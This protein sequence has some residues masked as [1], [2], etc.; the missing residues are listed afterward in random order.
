MHNSAS[1]GVAA[2]GVSRGTSPIA[3]R[4]STSGRAQE[5]SAQETVQE[6]DLGGRL[7]SDTENERGP[8]NLLPAS[9]VLGGSLIERV[10]EFKQQNDTIS[11]RALTG[12]AAAPTALHGGSNGPYGFVDSPRCVMPKREPAR[13]LPEPYL[14]AV[15]DHAPASEPNKAINTT[16]T[17]RTSVR[18]RETEAQAQTV[19]ET[20]A[21]ASA[22]AHIGTQAEAL[23]EAT[24]EAPAEAL[25]GAQANDRAES[26]TEAQT[27]TILNATQTEANVAD[28]SPSEVLVSEVSEHLPEMDSQQADLLND[29]ELS[30]RDGSFEDVLQW[31]ARCIEQPGLHEEKSAP[32]RG[33][34]FEQAEASASPESTWTLGILGRS[35]PADERA[36]L[37]VKR[38]VLLLILEPMLIG[39]DS[40]TADIM[41]K[42]LDKT[43]FFRHRSVMMN[44]H[45]QMRG[46]LE[47]LM[48]T[49]NSATKRTI[50]RLCERLW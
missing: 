11:S 49:T 34:C 1:F 19:A 27:E 48:A 12:Q 37:L 39:T 33:R 17:S 21:E 35:G 44:S 25:A 30:A 2:L 16:S 47:A 24:D 5:A 41:T 9:K 15:H 40:M 29:D 38:A 6:A 42:P 4:N 20:P 32:E 22:G 45:S 50:S 18:D 46:Q 8:V 3:G 26:P 23:A 14:A 7:A 43:A 28:H 10:I 36:V 13:K 31:V